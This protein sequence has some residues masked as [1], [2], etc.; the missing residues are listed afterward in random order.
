MTATDRADDLL[1]QAVDLLERAAEQGN[2]FAASTLGFV[3]AQRGGAGIGIDDS[4]LLAEVDRLTA[5]GR[6][7]EAIGIVA[8]G[9]ES[10]ARRLRRKRMKRT[11]ML[12]VASDRAML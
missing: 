9:D 10:I 8:G 6:K 12:S 11:P 1:R 3:R 7:R 2:G 4:A 5:A